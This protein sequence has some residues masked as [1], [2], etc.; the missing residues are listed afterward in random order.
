[1]Q[2][3]AVFEPP[4]CIIT[5]LDGGGSSSAAGSGSG[6]GSGAS[7]KLPLPQGDDRAT[8]SPRHASLNRAQRPLAFRASSA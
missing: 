8:Q 1:M 5:P 4:T 7:R 3:V 6:S 2:P